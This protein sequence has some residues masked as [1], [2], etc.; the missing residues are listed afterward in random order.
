MFG[1][2]VTSSNRY[3]EPVCP[4]VVFGRA[5][6][7]V[8][9]YSSD[10]ITALTAANPET[11]RMLDGMAAHIARTSCRIGIIAMESASPAEGFTTMSTVYK[12]GGDQ[13]V[14]ALTLGAYQLLELGIAGFTQGD[15]HMG[16]ILL[17][18]NYPQYFDTRPDPSILP[19][20]LLTYANEMDIFE[21]R[22]AFIIDFGRAIELS[23]S[24]QAKFDD[25]V[26][27]F[28]S[29]S[30]SR[31][32]QYL[33]KCM[34]TIYEGGIFLDGAKRAQFNSPQ[35]HCCLLYTSDAADE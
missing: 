15:Y 30:P 25:Y 2:I 5:Y 33:I 20:G 8:D 32:Q 9:R 7:G 23:P 26:R 11:E 22:R 28:F 16:N 31:A 12:R 34:E 35:Y 24:R 4:T 19:R 13:R 27:K 1:E 21:N 29:A 10:F 6:S 3:L 18:D 14:I 17:S